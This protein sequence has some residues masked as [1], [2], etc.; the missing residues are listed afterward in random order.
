[1]IRDR[2]DR[3]ELT[4]RDN[5]RTGNV[6]VTT[7][8]PGRVHCTSLSSRPEPGGGRRGSVEAIVARE[9]S[10]CS[11]R[12]VE[13]RVCCELFYFLLPKIVSPNTDVAEHICH[14]STN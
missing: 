2:S 4:T 5:S 1:M 9:R 6:T 11:A 8:T 7:A 12:A 3:T 13:T 14:A 10:T